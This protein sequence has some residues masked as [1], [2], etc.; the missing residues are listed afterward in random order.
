MRPQKPHINPKFANVYLKQTA[1]FTCFA[2]G[3]NISYQWIIGSGSFPS[4][5][6]GINSNTLVIPSVE[7]SDDNTYSC[8]ASNEAGGVPSEVAELTV[9]GMHDYS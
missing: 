9:I 8:V 7:L 5:M 3:Y 1:T 2:I 4:K 6:T